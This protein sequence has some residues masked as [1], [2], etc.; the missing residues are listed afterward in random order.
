[1]AIGE[2]HRVAS[3]VPTLVTGDDIEFFAE[4]ID[5][6][7]LSLVAELGSEDGNIAGLA[8]TRAETSTERTGKSRRREGRLR[9][10]RL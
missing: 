6:L 7:P 1:M 4:K 3:V 2:L 5:D 10:L 9:V 8:H